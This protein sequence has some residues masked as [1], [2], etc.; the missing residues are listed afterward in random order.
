[1]VTLTI[2]NEGEES[3]PD[4]HRCLLSSLS[5]Q[6]QKTNLLQPQLQKYM[7]SCIL[8]LQKFIE[9]FPFGTYEPISAR[10]QPRIIISK[11]PI[12]LDISGLFRSRKNQTIHALTFGSYAGKH[13]ALNDPSIILKLKLLKPHVKK[14]AQSNRPQVI[15][16]IFSYGKNHNLK[17]F[18]CSSNDIKKENWQMIKTLIAT[19]EMGYHYPVIPCRHK[20]P[21]RLNC[22]PLIENV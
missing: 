15:L 13:S 14:H 12:D 9:I 7:N 4:I 11:T 16:H 6:N 10:I 8:W 21:F 22:F 18:T 5:H 1:M 2:K 17:Y 20:C 3:L 19:I